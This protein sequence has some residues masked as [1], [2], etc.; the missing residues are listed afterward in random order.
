MIFIKARNGWGEL[1]TGAWWSMG[2]FLKRIEYC[3]TIKF[4]K[5]IDSKFKYK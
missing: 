1:K 2:L 5:F 3:V 4:T